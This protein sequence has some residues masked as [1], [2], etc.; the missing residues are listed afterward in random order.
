LKK[1]LLLLFLAFTLT[2]SFAQTGAYW[3]QKVDYT[4][5]VSLNDVDHTLDGYVR[6]QYQNNAPDSLYF[7][8]FHVWPNAFKNDRTAFSDQLLENGRTDFYFSNDEQKGYLNRLDF[9]V[10]KVTAVTED[11]PVHQD[12]IK[13][14]LPAP[15]APGQSIQ[16]ETPFHVKL[17]DHF[18]RSGHVNQSYQV[19]QWYPK[20]AVYDARG[21]HEMPYLDQ[22]EF[23]S[24]FGDYQ[25]TIN[26]P[27]NYVLAATGVKTKE[28]KEAST[29]VSVP[30]P[31][32]T[33]VK[34]KSVST[35]PTSSNIIKSVTYTQQ[36]IHDFAWFAD[37]E[38]ERLQD[39]LQLPSGIVE[40]NAYYNKTNSKAWKNSIGYIKK[41]ILSKSNWIGEY[42]YPVVSVVE[43]AGK[44][45]GGM[46]YPTITLISRPENDQMLDFLINHEV[47]HNWFYGI[48]A[49]NERHH[50]WMDEGMNSYYD[51]RYGQWK[52]T[53]APLSP[54]KEKSTFMS[55]R[56]PDD[57]IEDALLATLIGLKK[58]QP[59][60]TPSETFSAANYALVAYT[61][62]AQWMKLLEKETGLPVFDSIM[63]T[64]YQQ[65][66]F[67]HPY[68][69]DFK[70][71]AVGVSGKN[72]DSLF[73]LLIKKGSL[74]KP[75][76]K[77][78][79]LATFFSL[80][81]TD[82]Y[83]YISIAPMIGINYYDKLMIGAFIHN[84]TLPLPR[85][86]FFAAP[87]YATGSKQF[88]GLGRLAY[89]WFPGDRGAQLEVSVAGAHFT[90][91]Q[92]IDSTS[93]K[94]YQPFTK[95]APSIKYTF[96][97]K[98]PRSTV[99]HYLQWKTFLITET[100]LN[101]SRDT[102]QQ[103]DVITYP[104]QSRYLNQLQ[105]V[106]EN[107]RA[108]YPYRAQLKAEQGKGFVRLDFTGNY[109]FN[110]AQG[111]GLQVRLFAGKFMYTGEKTF[112]TQYETDRYHLNMTGANGYEDYTYSNYFTGRNEFE[113]FSSQQIMNR[114]GAFK[115]RTDLLSS[116]IGKT[117]DWLG[118]LNFS[119]S[120]P[121]QVNP[122]EVLPIKIPLRIFLDIGT[123]SE[124]WK[125][126]AS[127]GR[128]LYDAGLQL[129]LLKNTV[130]I[131]FPI[132][133]SKVYDNYFKS[134]ITEKRFQKNISFSIDLQQNFF[135]KIIPQI[136][137]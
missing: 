92:F 111:G 94:N 31:T 20:P 95:I 28:T 50:P 29:A 5:D 98:N 49:S 25:V 81:E 107:N 44:G 103:L 117:D 87:L 132:L 23:Y 135:K 19:T 11:H 108:L 76:K 101:F 26:L 73:N 62:S 102:I 106:I 99:N 47:G 56:V 74:Q 68:P 52:K 27:E 6:I 120:I 32:N 121:K 128:F 83:N 122:L 13:L 72:L 16:I 79:R 61:K 14:V 127:T 35:T 3:Q 8:W 67:K 130:N 118:A 4:I 114:D 58:D 63:R 36:N 42:P 91:D 124:A 109:F 53:N 30:L 60:K 129:S 125:K 41:A 51:N 43:D 22:G 45:D 131:Y 112:L 104:T 86:R 59:I 54:A 38:F 71:V 105:W 66:K 55:K 89:S 69:E 133:Y 123:Y 100:G 96:A 80:K 82:K 110:Y 116:K 24:E 64:Y 90:A 1:T 84:Y 37:K 78:I 113:G 134:T 75:V 126:D 85:F 46:E 115:V 39:T 137:L 18:S 40:V 57:E 2:R 15:L 12:I 93:K 65:W 17:P 33:T 48:L 70:Q 136:T 34:N 10:N 21:W 88:N 119:T 77:G 97:Q 9:K 7:I